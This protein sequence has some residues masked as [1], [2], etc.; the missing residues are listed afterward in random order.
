[1]IT[2]KEELRAK[3]MEK[4]YK[5]LAEAVKQAQSE[6][7][8]ELCEAKGVNKYTEEP[9]RFPL[10]T[11][12]KLGKE[13]IWPDAD[14]DDENSYNKRLKALPQNFRSVVCAGIEIALAERLFMKSGRDLTNEEA[15]IVCQLLVKTP[16][17]LDDAHELAEWMTED[18][19]PKPIKRV[20][21]GI[22][23][24]KKRDFKKGR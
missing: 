19:T 10:L 20:P 17:S 7:L 8:N 2:T 21:K 23:W 18:L 5:P 12:P 13:S 24:N 22:P 11:E 14:T 9:R 16:V 1:M 4:V 3:T 6:A 15:R